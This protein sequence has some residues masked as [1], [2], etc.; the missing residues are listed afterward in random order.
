MRQF[1]MMRHTTPVG[2]AGA[3]VMLSLL[4]AGC[5][6]AHGGGVLTDPLP[7]GTV[8]GTYEGGATFG[9]SFTCTDHTGTAVLQGMIEYHDHA[10]S[11]ITRTDGDMPTTSTFPRIDLHGVTEPLP[12]AVNS[13]AEAAD[14]TLPVAQFHGVYQPHRPERDVP[15]PHEAEPPVVDSP[16]EGTFQ[17]DVFD[18]GESQRGRKAGITGDA[19]AIQLT[20]GRYHGYTRA[21]YIKGGN[22]QLR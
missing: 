3:L 20:G 11:A 14:S 13:C 2:L 18:Q 7:S 21:G 5:Q 15:S 22:I 6:R 9:F 1:S 17:I 10:P 19:F 12:L 8:H 4:A 16:E